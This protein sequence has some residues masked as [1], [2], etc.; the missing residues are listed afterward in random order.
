MDGKPKTD[1]T[2]WGNMVAVSSLGIHMVLCTAAGVLGGYALDQWLDTSPVCVLLLF[3][4]G[5][6]AGGWQVVREIRR[7]SDSDNQ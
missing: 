7:L 2:T 4:L 1:R 5:V 6:F 3:V